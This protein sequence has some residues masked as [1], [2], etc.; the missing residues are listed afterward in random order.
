MVQSPIFISYSHRDREW[1]SRL[2]AHL[3]VLQ[4]EGLIDAWSDENLHPGDEWPQGIRDA[5]DRADI[6]VLLVSAHFLSSRFIM[7]KEMPI[8]LERRQAGGL[9]KLLP[10]VVTP[11]NW[12]LSQYLKGIEVRP[13][14]RDSVARGNQADQEADLADLT[15]EVAKLLATPRTAG[16]E[17]EDDQQD[18]KDTAGRDRDLGPIRQAPRESDYAILEVRLAHR[19]WDR[20]NVEISLTYSGDAKIP[21]PL[22][23][24]VSF[25]L[26]QLLS[27][28]DATEYAKQLYHLLFP[29]PPHQ[30]LLRMAQEYARAIRA[31]LRLR[32]AIDAS[33]RE[34]HCVRWELLLQGTQ[35]EH[36]LSF[37]STYLMRYAGA[38]TRSWRDIERQPKA[39]LKAML[40]A[41]LTDW[42][43]TSVPPPDASDLAREEITRASAL[44]KA[45]AVEAMDIRGYLNLEAF[46]SALRATAVDILYLCVDLPAETARTASGYAG[47]EWW[48]ARLKHLPLAEAIQGLETPPRLVVLTPIIRGE[49]ADACDSPLRWLSILREAYELAQTGVTGVLT[50]QGPLDTKT[51]HTF[52]ETFFHNLGQDG[53]MDYALHVARLALSSGG[54]Q[55]IPVLISGLR[56]ARIWYVPRFT[57]ETKTET[58]WE[59]L[60]LKIK[61]GG[62]TPILGPGLNST[63]ARARR[64]IALA[65]AESYHY[66]MAFHE[67][68]SLPQV[69]QYVASVY[70][71]DFFY[72]QYEAR[73]REFALRRFGS[74][75]TS[76]Q[77][78]LPLDPLLAQAL[79]SAEGHDAN[80]PHN[81][82][83]TLPFCLYITASLNS[84]LSDALRRV[85]GKAPQEAVFGLVE[86]PGVQLNAEPSPEQ[87]LV[88]HL[89]GRFSDLRSS[90]LTEDDYFDFLIHFWKERNAVPPVVRA[91]LTNSSLLFLGFKMH[92]W[93]FR[94]L[95]RSLLAQEGAKRRSKHMHVAV[96]IDPDEDQVM[97]PERAR[98]YLENYFSEFTD[99]D[100]N[101]YWGS[102]EDFLRELKTRWARFGS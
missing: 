33:A 77:Q 8:L 92:H 44:L 27:M 59:T 41:G 78:A 40:V 76:E 19:E 31:P 81:I 97:D 68:I 102:P 75:L 25:D 12:Q 66:P 73:F 100:I 74:L 10:L 1:L 58:T 38:D 20:Y 51:W 85:P 13:K 60:L 32:V 93:D 9:K 89:F 43:E 91:T 3:G 37:E 4:Q 56:T 69:A 65:W 46:K 6:A 61:R 48:S 52:L 90:V 62:C 42:F 5:L 16:A 67:R 80:E 83:A 55:W 54:Q 35:A 84:C 64:E 21:L 63:I 57:E 14:H 95:F 2:Q 11:C 87:P 23:H 71:E 99:A 28:R 7:E 79:A 47:L 29:E 18:E 96:Q 24:C 34:L 39:P 50:T 15:A 22:M 30:D 82:L 36:A 45:Y 72:E 88:Y 101:V 53:R 70:G 17:K 49:S 98:D 86:S 94:V 26:P